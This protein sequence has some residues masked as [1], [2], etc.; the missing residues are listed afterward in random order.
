MV[1]VPPAIWPITTDVAE[2]VEAQTLGALR[3]IERAAQCLA[4]IPAIR[5]GARSRTHSEATIKEVTSKP[6]IN[7]RGPS[8]STPTNIYSNR[9]HHRLSDLPVDGRKA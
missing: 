9:H 7:S 3:Q 2:A 1:E 8:S 5:D 4:G 6:M